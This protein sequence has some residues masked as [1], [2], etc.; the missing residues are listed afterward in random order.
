MKSCAEWRTDDR[1]TTPYEE[2]VVTDVEGGITLD[3][4]TGFGGWPED[5]QLPKIGDTVRLYGGF[6]RNVCGGDIN[7]EPIYWI[8]IAEEDAKRQKWSDEYHAR[9]ER[10]FVENEERLDAEC[11]A[12]PTAL[13]RR[14]ESFREAGGR[15]WRVSNESYE[16]FVCAQAVVIATLGSREAILRWNSINSKEPPEGYTP[17]DYKR[18]HVELPGFSDQHSG[19]TYGAA[20]ALAL[21]LVEEH[22]EQAII[23]PA[24]LAPISGDPRYPQQ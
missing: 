4:G 20:V 19:N 10:E 8:T 12:L 22:P 6:G 2:G 1:A 18:Q 24:A 7:G 23:M 16:M 17:Y 15:E 14:I 3:C 13:R 5:K 9:Q 21:M 11:E